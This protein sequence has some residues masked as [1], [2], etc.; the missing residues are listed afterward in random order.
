MQQQKGEREFDPRP[1]EASVH[2]RG[3]DTPRLAL[4]ATRS[5]TEINYGTN[6]DT[7]RAALYDIHVDV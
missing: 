1:A 5:I 4:V 7:N 2:E 3:V 6:E